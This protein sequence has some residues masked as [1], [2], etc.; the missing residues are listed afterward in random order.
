M[1]SEAK[2]RKLGEAPRVPPMDA[3]QA[4]ERIEELERLLADR[5]NEIN[6]LK[7]EK[8]ELGKQV[9]ELSKSS[10][11]KAQQSRYW[12]K[13]EHDRFM[14]ALR[15]YGRKDVKSIAAHVATRNPTQVRTHAQKYFLKL[16]REAERGGASAAAAAAA[17]A[18]FG[19]GSDSGSA[20][21][22]DD[23]EPQGSAEASVKTDRH[24]PAPGA[25]SIRPQTP[26]SPTPEAPSYPSVE[27]FLAS[28]EAQH[29]VTALR[30][31]EGELDA[32]KRYEIIRSKFLPLRTMEQVVSMVQAIYSVYG[33]G[34]INPSRSPMPPQFAYPPPLHYT[35]IKMEPQQDGHGP[36]GAMPPVMLPRFSPGMHPGLPGSTPLMYHHQQGS[37]PTSHHHWGGDL[38][39]P[40]SQQAAAGGGLLNPVVESHALM[41]LSDQM[42]KASNA[43]SS[44]SA[45]AQQGAVGPQSSSSAAS[46]SQNTI[47]RPTAPS[48][49][50]DQEDQELEHLTT[51]KANAQ[52]AM[53]QMLPPPSASPS[54][55][56]GSFLG[57]PIALSPMFGH[58]GTPFGTGAT[59]LPGMTGTP[60]FTGA[61]SPLAFAR[62][63]SSPLYFFNGE[64][65]PKS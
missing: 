21:S 18:T 9:K 15:K 42:M 38:S 48:D 61:P 29:L 52:N 6:R 25:T 59:P 63:V 27:H 64:P 28:P 24:S 57:Q 5:Q 13:D 36:P 22:E 3:S 4:M 37:T 50:Y 60:L 62:P 2:R 44:S 19:L 47:P 32:A 11:K 20:D 49:D 65:K 53:K 35:E 14:E 7:A 12:R 39:D 56:L 31:T 17:A 54:G 43:S 40:T 58:G 51:T 41:S 30:A 46:A 55:G 1:E 26:P 33:P 8:E 23:M 34:L 16:K 45:Q 10:G